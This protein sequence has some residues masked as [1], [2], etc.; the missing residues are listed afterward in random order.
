MTTLPVMG[1]VAITP[2]YIASHTHSK[3]KEIKAT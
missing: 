3:A 1:D 2:L